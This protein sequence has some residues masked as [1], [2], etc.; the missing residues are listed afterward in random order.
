MTLRVVA[1]D[2]TA[3]DRFYSLGAPGTDQEHFVSA[4]SVVGIP[5]LVDSI[6]FRSTQC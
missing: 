6:L 4:G 3:I 1:L 2:S 5:S